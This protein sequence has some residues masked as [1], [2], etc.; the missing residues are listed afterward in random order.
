MPS[1]SSRIMMI[2]VEILFLFALLSSTALDWSNSGAISDSIRGTLHSEIP[3]DWPRRCPEVVDEIF[4]ID[5]ARPKRISSNNQT[6]KYNQNEIFYWRRIP[7]YIPEQEYNQLIY[8]KD[9]FI[10]IESDDSTLTVS[11]MDLAPH[12]SQ[13]SD[14]KGFKTYL[15]YRNQLIEW[16]DSGVDI[17]SSDIKCQ[18]DSM[19]N[20]LMLSVHYLFAG[21]AVFFSDDSYL[22]RFDPASPAILVGDSSVSS[23]GKQR[24]QYI[25]QMPE[26][27]S[28]ELIT[29]SY[30][31][32]D[33]VDIST[34]IQQI[35]SMLMNPPHT[36]D[37]K[38]HR[39]M[40]FMLD[41]DTEKVSA[42]AESAGM[43]VST[44]R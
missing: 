36:S 40:Q 44:Y 13:Y 15:N 34:R 18:A 42:L 24:I 4:T 8:V 11:K 28:S 5:T 31:L 9:G 10:S 19:M 6:F 22:L 37:D 12:F 17:E 23:E 1:R 35:A 41:G 27:L 3:Y 32:A 25:F 21:L 33:D 30:Y 20:D 7:I 16:I 26:A 38:Y 14:I 29:I 39:I 2:N 43:T